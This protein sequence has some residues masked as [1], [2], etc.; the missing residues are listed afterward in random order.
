VT[1]VTGR[2]LCGGSTL[3]LP[4]NCFDRFRGRRASPPWAQDL[5]H[6]G[7]DGWWNTV[8]SSLV[9]SLCIKRFNL[10]RGWDLRIDSRPL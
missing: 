8:A 3:L 4:H 7:F 6:R 9:N 1:E 10:T 5:P 2:F